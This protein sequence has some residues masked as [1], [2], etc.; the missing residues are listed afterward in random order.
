MFPSGVYLV[1][2]AKQDTVLNL[3]GTGEEPKILQVKKGTSIITDMIG[4]QYHTQ[5]FSDPEEFKPARW[6]TDRTSDGDLVDA[7]EHTAF[8]VGPRACPGKKFA[9]TEAVCL[10]AL[11]LRDWKVVP[12]LS[13]NV[14]TGEKETTEEWRARVMHPVMGITMGVRDIPLTFVRRI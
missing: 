11:L 2:E 4:V 7:E 1:R 13:V 3:S 6:Y 5:Y 8:S 14:S 9:T 12:L 10:L